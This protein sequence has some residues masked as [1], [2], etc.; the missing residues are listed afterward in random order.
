MRIAARTLLLLL[1]LFC[2]LLLV[3]RYWVLPDIDSHRARIVEL[4]QAQIGQP[5]EI[6]QLAAGWDGWNPRLDIDQLRVVDGVDHSVL[7]ALP[8]VR[9][10]LAWTSLLFLDL[11]FKE[12]VL[13]GPQFV[14]R[15]DA[16]GMLHMVGLTVD[17]SQRRDDTASANWLL[18]QRRILIH[19]AQ[20]T[21]LDEQ[22]G[23]P[24]LELKHV[25][26]RLESRFGHHHFGLTGTP[27]AEMAAPLDLRGD[28]AVSSLPDWRTSTGRIYLRLDYADLAA[29][30][31]WVPLPVPI[32]S[33][34]GA[35]RLWF[36]F[37]SGEVHELTADVALADVEATL[38]SGLPELSLSQLEGRVGWRSD[39]G[40]TE[41]FTRQLSFT[42]PGN[43]HVDPTDFKLILHAADKGH[44]P[45]GS[46]AFNSLQLAPLTQV[47]ANL[48]LPESWRVDLARYAPRGRLE[49]G[50]LQWRGEAA[51]PETFAAKVRFVDLGL[52]AQDSLPGM[53]GLSGSLDA[54][55]RSGTL[56]V[57][58]RAV[59]LL[60]PKLFG[61]ALGLENM[62]SRVDWSREGEGYAI[63]IEQLSFSGRNLSGSASGTYRTARDGP[64]SI[65]LSAQLARTDV[66][67]LYRYLP[68]ML[69]EAVRSWLKRSLVSGAATETRL[70]LVG[71]LADFPFGNGRRGQFLVTTK[72][73]DVTFDYAEHWPAF[74]GVDAELRF[75]GARMRVD[76]V[77]GHVFDLKL[78]RARAEIADFRPDVPVLR[79]DGEASGPTADAFKYLSESP[80]G[81]WIGG[82]TAGAQASG[83]GK[84]TLQLELPLGK[85]A[86]SKATGE[87]TFTGNRLRLTS[88]MP[89]ATQLT[90]KLSFTNHELRS[91]QLTAQLLGGPARFSLET[92]DGQVHVSGQG[93]ADLGQLRVEYPTLV[94]LQ[95]LSGTTPWQ[96]AI[97]VRP[98]LTTWVFESNLKGAT[99]TL[100]APMNKPASESL[101]LQIERR[102]SESGH[103][104]IAIRYG[105]VGRLVLHRRLAASGA[106]VE[107]G[108]LA[109]GG[110]QGEPDRPGLWVRGN[111][112]MLN[113]DGWLALRQQSEASGFGDVL[114]LG[115]MDL[116]VHALDVFGRR[117]NELHVGATRNP[118]GW[119]MDLR[120]REL[121]GSARWLHASTTHPNGELNA[122]LQRLTPPASA[123]PQDGAGNEAPR[124]ST[125]RASMANSWPEIDIVADSLVLKDRDL[126]RL[127]LTAQPQGADWLIK[128]LQLGNDD[129][130]LAAEGL[131]RVSGRAQQ[132]KLDA[133]LDIVDAGRYLA[134]FG[135]PNTVRGAATRVKGELAW[136]G[137]PQAFDYPTLSGSFR[138]DAGPGQFL[139]LDPGPAKLLGVLSLQSLRRRL[140]FDYQD[141]FGEGFAFDEITGDVQIKNGVMSSNNVAIVGPAASVTISGETNL[142]RE[143]QQLKVRVVPKLSSTVSMGAAA[144]LLANPIIGA[145]VGAGTLL[146]QK[147]MQDPIEQ[148][149]ANDYV[150]GGTWSDPA[151]EKVS[152]ASARAPAN[153]IEGGVR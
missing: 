99:I 47:A 62:Q 74:S 43:L 39:S 146:A 129:G 126:G 122:R 147:I 103:D 58:S 56:R 134:R 101:P 32:R 120:G 124:A 96:S 143:T 81:Q 114:G 104:T 84:L 97:V 77:R 100:P 148:I 66:S 145:A 125:E 8:Q 112:D 54:T 27:P 55:E 132:T 52:D 70:R 128:H 61:E 51:A 88:D 34:K 4:L 2:T 133:T 82:I 40:E 92:R 119:Q 79:I 28:V 111:V 69:P 59:A 71:D 95:R 45:S 13:D 41:Y 9:M 83:D 7:L 36:D 64:G 44:A 17:P 98:E 38:A 91:Q 151:V 142:A 10:T 3:L 89:A 93:S 22:R 78:A 25:E 53:I 90:G 16:Q 29:W 24:Q 153:P 141:L 150:I 37:A 5:V 138:V 76:A 152:N 48:P 117:F 106:I 26:F 46:V 139:K 140:S 108:L 12:L 118:A 75:E 130:R 73:Q 127:E 72:L 85:P 144:L 33:G 18:R 11:R 116:S 21:W 137:G 57:Q 19:D 102:A 23:A 1:A 31:P 80:I 67:Q 123:P 105:S 113:V 42:A 87:Y 14:L 35:L 6:G 20:I 149:F 121:T 68:L 135:L 63:S 49:Q 136:D 30:H 86:A 107:S 50:E 110:A 115:G 131:W 94:A 109:L 60:M 15:R 65:D